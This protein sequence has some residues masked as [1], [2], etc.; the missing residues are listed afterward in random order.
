MSQS[1]RGVAADETRSSRPL[2]VSLPG[3]GPRGAPG[4]TTAL[5]TDYYLITL[6]V[7][8]KIDELGVGDQ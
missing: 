4:V 6:S 2:G 5:Y 7:A 8:E 3:P 1:K